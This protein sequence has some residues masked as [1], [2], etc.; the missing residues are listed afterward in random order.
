M[1]KEELTIEDAKAENIYSA[2]Y[3]SRDEPVIS[4]ENIA[5]I[6][7]KVFDKA[8]MEKFI[9]ELKQELEILYNSC[10]KCGCELGKKMVGDEIY[11]TCINCGRVKH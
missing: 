5:K 10:E 11:D 9:E 6:C 1:S 2:I 8:E 7:G 4:L 3:S